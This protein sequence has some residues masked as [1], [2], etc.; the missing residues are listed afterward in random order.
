MLDPKALSMA[1]TD[2]G[3]FDGN[4]FGGDPI[5]VVSE[6]LNA[7]NHE[8][9]MAVRNYAIGRSDQMSA[10]GWRSY[11]ASMELYTQFAAH[12]CVGRL[13]DEEWL[14]LARQQRYGT[15]RP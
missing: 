5:T 9:L 6:H 14:R 11:T 12:H 3:Q 4:R 13:I 7:R 2:F 10:L 15:S 1:Y 8:V